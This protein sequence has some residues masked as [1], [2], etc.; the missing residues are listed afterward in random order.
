MEIAKHDIKLEIQQ[1][2]KGTV[3]RDFRNRVIDRVKGNPDKYKEYIDPKTGEVID[4]IKDENLIGKILAQ[5]VYPKWRVL[6]NSQQAS[7]TKFK[8]H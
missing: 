7:L 2:V 1:Y 4:S 5:K 6:E 3:T 8:T